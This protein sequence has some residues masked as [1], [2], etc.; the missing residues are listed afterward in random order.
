MNLPA[1]DP[2]ALGVEEAVVMGAADTIFFGHYFFPKAFRQTSPQF[3]YNICDLVENPANRKVA[4]KI[5]RG[6]AKTTVCRVILAKRIAYALSNT[7]LIVSET[8]EHSIET[9]KW[10]RRAIEH[11]KAFTGAFGL[12]KG[13]KWTDEKITIVN[14]L[15]GI[16]ITIVATGIF[17][18]TRGLNIDDYRPDFILLDDVCDEDNTKTPEMR[19]KVDTRIAGAIYQS[20]APASENAQATMCMLQTPLHREDAIEQAMVD[21][22][23]V[24]MEISIFDANGESVWPARWTT[25]EVEAEKD[26]Y[27]NKNQLSVWYREKEVTVTADELSFFKP[28]WLNYYE[29]PP[30]GGVCYIGV[31]PTPPPKDSEQLTSDAK[32]DDAVIIAIKVH[33]QRIYVMDYYTTKSPSSQELTNELFNFHRRYRPLKVG[34]ETFLFQR[35]VK[36][37]AEAA[38][39]RN[40]QFFQITPCEDRRKK[41]VRIRQNVGDWAAHGQLYVHPRMTELIDQFNQYPD[42]NHD[43][44]L[45]ALSIALSLI[46]PA[47]V[48]YIEGDYEEIEDEEMGEDYFNAP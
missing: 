19:R 25:E 17:G 40:R 1:K 46:S 20:L 47:E 29:V 44:L 48:D 3:H 15:E 31:D 26:T 2:I 24:S 11:N 6:G 16:S 22:S 10:I 39:Q 43:D 9:L 35:T 12:E 21:P 38:M 42:V 41:S 8:A 27:R 5:F 7:I 23:Y 28:T 4:V 32:L 33:N 30:E 36:T 13:D 18:Q 34:I 45:D 14:R 37:N